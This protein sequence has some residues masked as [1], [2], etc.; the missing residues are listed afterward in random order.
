ME[1]LMRLQNTTIRNQGHVDVS[2]SST[3]T[4]PFVWTNLDAVVENKG[5][6]FTVNMSLMDNDKISWDLD[7]NMSFND[8][9]V[10]GL[11]TSVFD[12]GFGAR[13]YWAFA[14]RIANDRHYMPFF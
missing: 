2:F 13:H 5:Y 1:G 7:L 9:L 6:E 11:G 12:T 3:P 10:T 8:N 14:Q 4:Q